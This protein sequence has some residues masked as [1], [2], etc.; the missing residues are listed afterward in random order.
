MTMGALVPCC[1][2]GLLHCQQAKL[3][4]AAAAAAKHNFKH[5]LH[6]TRL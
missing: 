5:P 4:D 1:A 6:V 2:L 3:H